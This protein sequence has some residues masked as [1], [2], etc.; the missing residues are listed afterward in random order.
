MPRKLAVQA[1][2]RMELQSKQDGQAEQAVNGGL[3]CV[4]PSRQGQTHINTCRP[5][6]HQFTL[7]SKSNMRNMDH[8]GDPACSQHT[9]QRSQTVAV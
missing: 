9:Q 1:A 2:L 7:A 3:R 6:L 5:Q 8:Q 4:A